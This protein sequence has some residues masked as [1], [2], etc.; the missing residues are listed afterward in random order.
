VRVA[1]FV[2][3]HGRFESVARAMARIGQVD[4]LVIGGDITSGGSPGEAAA[5]VESWRAL[6]PTLLAVCGN[7]DSPAIDERLA[8]LGVSLHGR[9]V[10]VGEVGFC[11]VSGS[12]LSHIHA[13]YELP[14]Q[15]IERLSE[16]GL[17]A[18]HDCRLR[19]FCPHTPPRDTA[20]DRIWSGDH[21]G[22]TG[23]RSAIEHA[24]PDL[25]LCGHIHESRGLDAIG[26][27]RIVNPGPATEGHYALVETTGTAS[28]AL[29]P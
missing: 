29:D 9:G 1:Y 24:Q 2:D 12:P 25:V 5:A 27:T 6:A 7:W 11:G 18:I 15:E 23:I 17:T 19:I 14:E 28:V 10:A 21:I 4:V 13:P 20:C 16:D 3:T 22:S 26:R 8:E